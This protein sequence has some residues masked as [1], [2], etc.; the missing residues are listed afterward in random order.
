[1]IGTHALDGMVVLDCS[2]IL[3]GPFC[4]M[5]LADMGADVIKVEKPKGGDDTRRMGPPFVG[6][7]SAAFLQMN[8][9]KRS[10]VLDI[11]SEAGKQAFIRLAAKSDVLIENY[12]PGTLE[13][14]GLGYEELKQVNPG[15]V[16]CSISGFGRSGPYGKRAGFDLV[17]QG[18]SGL[19][20]INGFPGS[21]PAK[22]A[23]PV[24]DLNAGMFA[25]YGILAAYVHKLKTGEGQ[26]IE[27]SLLES[28]LAYTVWESSMYFTTG[29]NP[30]P[31]GSSHRLS[32]PYQ[33][34][35]TADGYINI[36]A[37]NQANW[38]RLCRAIDREDLLSDARFSDNAERMGHLSALQEELERTFTQHPTEYWLQVLE[39][40]GVPAGPIYNMSEVWSNEQVQARDMDVKLNHPTAGEIH[41]IGM[42]VKMHGTPGQIRAAAPLLGQHT[43]EILE[44]AGYSASEIDEMLTA[45]A[46]VQYRA[47]TTQPA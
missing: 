23:V 22:L 45:G 1:M 34:L 14:L 26:H 46:A 33:A 36:G 18:M 3:A 35:R 13:R 47:P 38:E 7:E 4:S 29:A 25:L 24:A 10:A 27:T 32:A 37:A 5:L 2:Q 19:M 42:A 20:S 39:I 43:R 44:F 40:A 41:N 30:G 6:G 16:Y 8:R 31:L 9:N 11:R 15:L 28:A 21:A 12:R 17:A